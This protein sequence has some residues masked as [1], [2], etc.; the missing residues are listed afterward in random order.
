M[1]LV[2]C[3]LVVAATLPCFAFCDATLAACPQLKQQSCMKLEP[4]YKTLHNFT[5]DGQ[6]CCS[7]CAADDACMA[8][9]LNDNA[10]TCFLH[11]IGSANPVITP[12]NCQ[13]GQLRPSI[14]PPTPKPAP[15]GAKN[16]IFF[17]SDD[18]RP[19][20]LAAYGQKQ[21]ITPVFDELAASSMVFNRAYCQQAICG[22]TR[23]SFLSGRR[24]QRTK[25][26]CEPGTPGCPGPDCAVGADARTLTPLL[27]ASP[28]AAQEL[29]RPL[30]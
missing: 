17:I 20:M 18:L 25:S 10:K 26:W 3:L 28:T 22:P 8:Y 1:H 23:N 5:G 21:M 12:G 6:A 13:S 16:V 9:T 15:A 27:T 11:P 19:E 30:P 24:P 14:K 29:H 7:A 2:Q 4:A